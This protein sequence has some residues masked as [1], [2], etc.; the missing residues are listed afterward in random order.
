[1]PPDGTTAAVAAANALCQRTAGL[2]AVWAG[3]TLY[4]NEKRWAITFVG[5]SVGLF[6]LGGA[7]A[8]L[9][10]SRGLRFLLGFATGGLSSLLTFDSYLSYV[11]A[12]VLVRRRDFATYGA[13]E[14]ATAPAS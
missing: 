12:M 5:A 8:W 10:L 1:M 6:A 14:P 3:D 7:V 9:T 11:L 2:N 4:Q 13:P